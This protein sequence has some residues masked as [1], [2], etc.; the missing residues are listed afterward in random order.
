MFK[1][2]FLVLGVTPLFL[3][4]G[5][6]LYFFSKL[7]LPV[8]MEGIECSFF[9]L[10]R[11]A[12]M[13]WVSMILVRTTPPKSFMD[14]VHAGSKSRFFANSK[15]LQDFLSVGML[16]FQILPHLLAEAEEKMRNCWQEGKEKKKINRLETL[17]Q[18]VRYIL[19]WVIELLD[20]PERLMSRIEKV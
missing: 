1:I 19:M 11:L 3:T 20:D 16:S 10:A 15:I 17:K 13:I 6:P 18:M 4:P 8:T 14:I 12:C 9:T 5:V 7:P 2:F